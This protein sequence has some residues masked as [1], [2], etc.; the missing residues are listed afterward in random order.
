M[1]SSNSISEAK[2]ETDVVS[3]SIGIGKQFLIPEESPRGRGMI[4]Q[5][6]TGRVAFQHGHF[7]R[8][9]WVFSLWWQIWVQDLIQTSVGAPTRKNRK[10]MMVAFLDSY[11]QYPGNDR[12]FE[13][14]LKSSFL[15]LRE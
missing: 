13:S 14:S 1:A 9:G 6:T 5:A 12:N 15:C 2:T 4:F 10:M 3:L 7:P 8:N 11:K